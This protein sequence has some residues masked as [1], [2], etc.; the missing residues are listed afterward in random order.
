MQIVGELI[1]IFII[2]VICTIRGKP[3]PQ[4]ANRLTTA[5]RRPGQGLKMANDTIWQ[6][7]SQKKISTS[8]HLAWGH[9]LLM[10]FSIEF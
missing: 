6:H 2:I 1:M 10:P 5:A 4:K 9:A 8:L 3:P 7:G